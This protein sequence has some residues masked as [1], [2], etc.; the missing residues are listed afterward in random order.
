MSKIARSLGVVLVAAAPLLALSAPAHAANGCS[1]DNTATT[2]NTNVTVI[3]NPTGTPVVTVDF[4]STSLSCEYITAA[5]VVTLT[6]ATPAGGACRT[7]VNGTASA[8]CVLVGNS[9]CTTT[10]EVNPG[11]HIRLEVTGGRGA[12]TDS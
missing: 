8:F 7:F 1:V 6:C 9:T 11:D 4:N 12:V 2:S 5:E 10:F 3:V